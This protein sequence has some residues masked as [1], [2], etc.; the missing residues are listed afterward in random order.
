[1]LELFPI[2]I[3]IY[4]EMKIKDEIFIELLILQGLNIKRNFNY[5]LKFKN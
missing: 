4:N 2:K 1:M 3:K 5:Q